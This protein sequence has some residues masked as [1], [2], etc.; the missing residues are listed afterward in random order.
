MYCWMVK[1]G[2][3]HGR[4]TDEALGYTIYMQSS[5][6][7]IM[8]M[9]KDSCNLKWRYCEGGDHVYMQAAEFCYQVYFEH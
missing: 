2:A 6:M 1:P 8:Q 7:C 5:S 9:K 3:K 4:K